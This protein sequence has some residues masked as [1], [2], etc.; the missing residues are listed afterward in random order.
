MITSPLFLYLKEVEYRFNRDDVDQQALREPHLG[1]GASIIANG[2]QTIE[3]LA[4]SFGGA[5]MTILD[6]SIRL[7]CLGFLLSVAPV[8]SQEVEDAEWDCEATL[9]EA[10]KDEA[11]VDSIFEE[12]ARYSDPPAV[13]VLDGRFASMK[14]IQ[15]LMELGPVMLGHRLARTRILRREAAEEVVNRSLEKN[16][17]CAWTKKRSTES[18]QITER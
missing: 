16:L 13:F 10:L 14:E 7:L 5:Q 1:L 15:E 4:L 12:R 11:H 17:V 18:L 6:R 2:P 9:K 3:C 8:S